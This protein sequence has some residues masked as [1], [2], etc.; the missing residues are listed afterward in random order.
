M[1]FSKAPSKSVERAIEDWQRSHTGGKVH[2]DVA[3]K[4]FVVEKSLHKVFHDSEEEFLVGVGYVSKYRTLIIDYMHE[5]VEQNNYAEFS[6]AFDV[7]KSSPHLLAPITGGSIRRAARQYQSQFYGI[8]LPLVTPKAMQDAMEY[9]AA[10]NDHINDLLNQQY[11][12]LAL[13]EETP[14]LSYLEKA[15]LNDYIR[16]MQQPLEMRVAMA[17]EGWKSSKSRGYLEKQS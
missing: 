6:V 14:E 1:L 11:K 15:Q 9:D 7:I 10:V 12:P 4:A 16:S 2:A 13:S 3:T 8:L 17:R 5:L